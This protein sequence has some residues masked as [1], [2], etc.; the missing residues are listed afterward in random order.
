MFFCSCLP[1]ISD[2]LKVKRSVKVQNEFFVVELRGKS[3]TNPDYMQ[4][5]F[6]LFFFQ[7]SL[8]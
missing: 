7:G 6:W 5:L 3:P 2:F 4:R 1:K 8:T